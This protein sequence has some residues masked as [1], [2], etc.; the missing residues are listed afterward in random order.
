[1]VFKG[2]GRIWF[3][4]RNRELV[5]F[6]KVSVYETTDPREIEILDN[7]K[8]VESVGGSYIESE[9]AEFTIEDEAENDE[10]E[11]DEKD[12]LVKEIKDRK[13]SNKAPSTLGRMHIDKLKKIIKEG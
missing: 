4:A 6:N 2:Y 3:P 13:L 5:N 9:D 8:Q 10:I 7:C 11:I 1:M 12:V